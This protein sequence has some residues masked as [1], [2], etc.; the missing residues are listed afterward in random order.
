L[1][2]ARGWCFAI[3]QRFWFFSVGLVHSTILSRPRVRLLDFERCCSSHPYEKVVSCV[4]NRYSC[5]I[6]GPQS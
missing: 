5:E 4:R 3:V 6:V 2:P 1:S